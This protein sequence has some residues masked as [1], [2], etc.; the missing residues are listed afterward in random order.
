M[1]KYDEIMEKIVVTEEMRTRILSNIKQTSPKAKNKILRLPDYRKYLP[2]AA[3]LAIL[4]IG[5]MVI[6]NI[7]GNRQTD[8]PLVYEQPGGIAYADNAEALS[9]YIGFPVN[10]I[11]SLPFEATEIT[12]LAYDKELAEISYADEEQTLYFRKSIGTEDNSGDF[13]TYDTLAQ[14][15]IKDCPITIKGNDKLY[16]LAVWNDGQYSYSIGIT[17]GISQDKLSV[18]IETLDW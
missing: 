7:L 10:E 14:I 3:C 2:V 13:N 6:P 1:N 17:N 18:L 16:N 4:L 11:S 5:A 8:T 9:S 15:T 12:Y